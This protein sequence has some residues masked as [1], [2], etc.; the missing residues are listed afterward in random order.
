MAPKADEGA[1]LMKV[2]LFASQKGGSSK[3][4]LCRCVAVAA[5][6][7][8]VGSIG[9]IDT[10]PQGTLTKWWKR[11]AAQ[12]PNLLRLRSIRDD[13]A[14]TLEAARANGL[15]YVFMDTQGAI[16]ESLAAV[17]PFAD[18]VIIPVRASP[19]DLDAVPETLRI[20]DAAA[21]PYAFILVQIKPNAS[22]NSQARLALLNYGTVAAATMGDRVDFASS[23]IDGRAV[24]ELDPNGRSA[25]EIM[26]IWDF[27]KDR[28]DNRNAAT[29]KEQ[30][31]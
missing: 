3:T 9:M 21:K 4:A 14:P 29:K 24:Q 2:I 15:A 19:D 7:A 27:V 13:L 25:A 22:I 8:G 26:E 20:I 16:T 11:R 28:A 6:Q 31:A 12:T 23:A 30:A 5:D 17:V 18:T 10:D 1:T